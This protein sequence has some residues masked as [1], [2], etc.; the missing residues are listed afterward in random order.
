MTTKLRKLLRTSKTA[1]L[2]VR[3]PF[4]HHHARHPGKL[5]HVVGH[6]H[7]TLAARMGCNV[8]IVHAD[9]LPCF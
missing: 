3:D 7:Q 5:Q 2:Q 8:Q 1:S 6:H 4:L 9:W